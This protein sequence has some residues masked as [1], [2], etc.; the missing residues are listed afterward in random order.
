[1]A[2]NSLHICSKRKSILANEGH[3]LV[4]G[5]P[6]S[7]KTTIALVKAGEHI[8]KNGLHAGQHILFLS[9]ARATIARV[10]Q[11]ARGY[12]SAESHSLLEINTYHGFA[13]ALLRSHGYLTHGRSPLQLLPPP[14]AAARNAGIDDDD[15]RSNLR[16]I[17]DSERLLGFDLFA[18][19]A[20][21]L[22]EGSSR[23]RALIS[24]CYPIIIVD[25]F[26][27][28]DVFEW[29][30]IKALGER[31]RIIALADPEQRI[32]QFRGADPARIGEFIKAFNPHVSD[33]GNENNRSNG[34]DIVAFG[35]DLL[36]GANVGAT[37]SDVGIERYSR[38]NN[39]LSKLKFAVLTA[40]KRLIASGRNDWSLA[41]LLGA[42]ELMLRASLF[43]GSQ[44]GVTPPVRHDVLIDPEGPT[45]A[46]ILIASVLE[47]SASPQQMAEILLAD[48]ISYIRGHRGGNISQADL[49]LATALEQY[50]RGAK[51]QGKNRK[52]L[53]QEIESIVQSR[54]ALTL[55]G[56]W[57]RI[58][59]PF[60]ISLKAQGMTYLHTFLR[61]RN[62]FACSRRALN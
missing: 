21:D 4:L 16:S 24:D 35:N 17:L 9:F 45:L 48:V 3:Q 7:G 15:R 31:S 19:L 12:I 51:L 38:S 53:A 61:M 34:T 2:G 13:W 22:L 43:L 28:T 10:A 36:T 54:F 49:K 60:A 55:G 18:E 57:K 1:M 37:Y 5:G 29:R 40:R 44:T 59:W 8:E 25:E 41:V 23:L 26:Q 32:Y 39:E 33:F 6:G 42:K 30:M 62:T 27:D 56:D 58:G 14:E 46:A 52:Q 11:Q 50:S 47:P 20:G